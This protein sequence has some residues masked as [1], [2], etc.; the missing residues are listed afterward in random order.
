MVAVALVERSNRCRNSSSFAISTSASAPQTL[1]RRFSC[2]ARL[3]VAHVSTI[4]HWESTC[5]T[6]ARRSSSDIPPTYSHIG[7]W[8][9]RHIYLLGLGW[10][11][12]LG[13]VS[14][15]RQSGHK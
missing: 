5:I 2:T 12:N 15:E 14:F 7:E 6:T 1:L 4:W 13:T 11:I 9:K 3:W 8:L 10:G